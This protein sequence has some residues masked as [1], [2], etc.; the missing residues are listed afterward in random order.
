MDGE[1]LEVKV[2]IKKVLQDF[3]YDFIGTVSWSMLTPKNG[4]FV[5]LNFSW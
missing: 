3:S 4:L 1:H 5:F 2:A